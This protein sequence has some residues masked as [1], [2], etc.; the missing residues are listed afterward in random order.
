M[1]KVCVVGL[2]Y[3]GL[4]T[5]ITL[6]KHNWHVIGFDIDQDKVTRINAFDPVIQEPELKDELQKALKKGNFYATNSIESAEFFIIAVPTPFKE[7]KKADLS[8]VWQAV[9]SI[10]HV[11]KRGDTIILESTVPVGTSEILA[12]KL[13]EKTSLIAGKDFFVAYCPERVLPG[14]IFY[15]LIHNS[16]IIGGIT[17]KSTQE[18]AELYRSFVQAELHFTHA[19]SAELVKLIENSS[20]DVQIAFANQV[21]SMCYSAGLDPFEIIGLANKHPRVSIL[22]PS[23]GVGGHCIAVDPWFLIE[24]FPEETGLLKTARIINDTKPHQVIKFIESEVKDYQ[25]KFAKKPKVALLG[26]TYKP[27]IDDMRESPALHIAQQLKNNADIITLVCE[28]NVENHHIE[29]VLNLNNTNLEEAIF[30]ADIIVSL[31]KHRSFLQ[32]SK[33]LFSGKKIL[34]FC[35]L[36][37]TK[38][39]LHHTTPINSTLNSKPFFIEIS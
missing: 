37:Y 30:Q 34:D 9:S 24:T 31:V 13:S 35:G 12:E 1:K 10:A 28:P 33:H 36:F 32:T 39:L 7:N 3:I 14:N 21:A 38:N 17:T 23:C 19:R 26:L 15:E 16:R 11:L 29:K 27:D 2:G 18:A 20:R 6:S 8:Y 5:A 22:Q 25:R 4:P